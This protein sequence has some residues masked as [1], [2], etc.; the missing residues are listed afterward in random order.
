VEV[1]EYYVENDIMWLSRSN[2]GWEGLNGIGACV[3]RVTE[4]G[5]TTEAVSCS[6]YSRQDMTAEAYGKGKRAYRGIEN[7]LHWVPDIGFRED[8]SRVRLGSA[9]E[10]INVIRH[11]G[12]NLLKQEKSCRM[13]VAGKRKK[14]N[15]DEDYLCRILAGLNVGVE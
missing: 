1:R 10:N 2:P 7:S 8:E 3:S 13:G 4:K 6:I 12:L 11:I 14:C 15:Y 9:A 5:N